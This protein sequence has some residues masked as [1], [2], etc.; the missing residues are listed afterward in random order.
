M[1]VALDRRLLI[2]GYGNPGRRDDGLGPAFASAL[3]A[4]E[5]PDVAVEAAYQLAIEDAALL[6]DCTDA[7]FV[8]ACTSSRA[9]YEFREIRPARNI[10]FSS[11]SVD[12]ESVLA[13]CEEHFRPAPNAWVLGI[14]GYDFSLGEEL[15]R[16]AKENLGLAL[17]FA[18]AFLGAW[19]TGSNGCE[20][21]A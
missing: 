5:F 17:G 3:D 9:P 16:G 1:T 21:D 18:R 15:T 13:I 8:D 2:I 6:A 20:H 7:L 19:R 12:P 4:M 14:R 10:S 11:H